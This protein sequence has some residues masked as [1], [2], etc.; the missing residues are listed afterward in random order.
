MQRLIIPLQEFF[1]SWEH[2]KPQK[3]GWDNDSIKRFVNKKK[4]MTTENCFEE[5]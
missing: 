1:D 5:H 4:M 2:M 3:D